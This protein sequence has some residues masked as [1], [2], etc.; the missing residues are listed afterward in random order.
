MGFGYG[1]ESKTEKLG[2]LLRSFSWWRSGR[3]RGG[4]VVAE[5]IGLVYSVETMR[6]TGIVGEGVFSLVVVFN[7]WFKSSSFSCGL[8]SDSGGDDGAD[9]DMD[10]LT[11]SL[12]AT[13]V[14][15]GRRKG[16][17]TRKWTPPSDIF[18]RELNSN[19]SDSLDKIRFPSLTDKL[20]KE[21]KILSICD[22]GIGMT[23]EDLIK[24]LGTTAKSG[25]SAF[26]EKMR[27]VEFLTLL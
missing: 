23:K 1:R 14:L 6:A 26:V 16:W 27:R 2:G 20:D 7:T 4:Y 18:L 13:A 25:T 10:M 3:S 5:G 22:R 11:K 15:E 8:T 9:D 21:Q 24:N 12:P 19:A 17:C